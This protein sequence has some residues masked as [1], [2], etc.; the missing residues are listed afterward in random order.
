MAVTVF[1][2]AAVE[3]K[4]PV[5]SPLASVVPAGCVSV[6]PADGV[7]ASITVAPGIGLS[8]PSRTVTLIVATLDPVLAVMTP[9]VT[10]TSDRLAL[11]AAG[12]PVAVKMTGL[13][14][15]PSDVARR[16][17]VPAVVPRVHEVTVATPLALVV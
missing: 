6:F 11:G 14:L 17:L 3:L 12:R 15:S 13:P 8:N 1:V 4:V 7:A 9:G 16:V 5:I 10:D 2:P